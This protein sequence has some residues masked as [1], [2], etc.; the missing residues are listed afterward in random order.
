M[1]PSVDSGY[2]P[3]T[4]VTHDHR[5]RQT[6]PPLPFLGEA[7]KTSTGIHHQITTA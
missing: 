5:L 3:T 4:L 7:Q 2:H 6:L 1:F